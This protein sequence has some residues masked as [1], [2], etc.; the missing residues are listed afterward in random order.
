M[1]DDLLKGTYISNLGASLSVVL[2]AIIPGGR[3]REP[4]SAR[5]FRSEW[6]LATWFVDKLFTKNHC[7]RSYLRH[8]AAENARWGSAVNDL[9]K[10]RGLNHE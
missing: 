1:S 9:I 3:S 7:N 2:C 8:M 6:K 4:F 5:C 10:E